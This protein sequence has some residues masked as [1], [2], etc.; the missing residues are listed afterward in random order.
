LVFKS[1]QELFFLHM[2]L[3]KFVCMYVCIVYVAKI[4]IN[5]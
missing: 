2:W 3:S 1:E 4:K 5:K